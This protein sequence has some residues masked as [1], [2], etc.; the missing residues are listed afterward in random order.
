VL[1]PPGTLYDPED[2]DGYSGV[3][4]TVLPEFTVSGIG[5]NSTVFEAPGQDIVGVTADLETL[6]A[7]HTGVDAI[8]PEAFDVSE[9]NLQDVQWVLPAPGRVYI[10][11]IES[12]GDDF[13]RRV[14][15]VTSD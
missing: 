2:G 3:G 9:L 5:R 12:D 14:F 10:V 1:F 8:G 15:E 7:A 4:G 13:N 11:D 6:V